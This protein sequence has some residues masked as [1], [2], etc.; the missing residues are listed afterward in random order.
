MK[1]FARIL[2]L[3]MVIL[4][5]SLLSVVASAS[6]EGVVP[7]SEEQA[8]TNV[9]QITH[10]DGSVEYTDKFNSFK[11]SCSTINIRFP[12]TRISIIVMI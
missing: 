3:L 9:W 8:P 10:A 6:D 11:V 7:S 4:T 12:F 2:L 1:K 5:M